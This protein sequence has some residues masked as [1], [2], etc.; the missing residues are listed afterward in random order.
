MRP[1]VLLFLLAMAL[2]VPAAADVPDLYV[3]VLGQ[4]PEP[5][6]V[7]V[8]PSGN[9]T[10]LAACFGQGGDHEVDATITI[11]LTDH[12]VPV[13]GVPAEDIWLEGGWSSL[14]AH[15]F[16]P[17]L[18]C[19]GCADQ[20][21]DINGVTTFSRRLAGGGTSADPA[22]RNLVFYVNGEVPPQDPLAGYRVTS[23]DLDADLVVNLVDLILF[24]EAFNTGDPAGDFNGDGRVDLLDLLMFSR[25][26]G[27]TCSEPVH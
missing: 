14:P 20:A 11:Q 5:V 10:P 25:A 16:A 9:G 6:T 18:P 7:Y 22:G 19:G 13:P 12:G 23:P 27:E 15:P 21:T 2:V 26:F 17:C 8:T 24:T 1:A 4:A 3:H